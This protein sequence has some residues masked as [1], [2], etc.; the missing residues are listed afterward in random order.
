MRGLSLLIV[1]I[2]MLSFATPGR[3]LEGG[4]DCAEGSDEDLVTAESGTAPPATP[5][6]TPVS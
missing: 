6:R 4:F 3:A 2:T 5:S 1:I